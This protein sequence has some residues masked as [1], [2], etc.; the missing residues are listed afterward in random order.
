MSDQTP[1]GSIAR[2]H[3]V[4]S[5]LTGSPFGRSLAEVI[6]L[7]DF[8]KTTAHRTLQSL[9]DVNYVFQDPTNRRYFL[10]SALGRLARCG[11]Q[12]DIATLAGR[13]MTRLAERTGDTIF[14]G[15]REGAEVVCVRV[16]LGEYPI[17]TLSQTLGD[18]LPIG[19]GSTGQALFAA[20]S[21]TER[22][23][24]LRANANWVRDYNYTPDMVED[25][26]RDFDTRGYALNQGIAVP[27]MIGVGL[28]VVA[29][30]G[31]AIA[32]IGVGA[33]DTRMTPDRIEDCVVPA[34]KEEIGRLVE[35]LDVLEAEGLF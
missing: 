28:P 24:I 16:E 33:I 32:A 18:R 6:A 20:S 15:V 34:M 17:R 25:L 27:Q 1:V 14:L 12:T 2:A 9:I 7:T 35:R 10:G 31:R 3:E 23:A 13:A 19:V 5:A 11:N 8:S 21:P 26:V 30:N 4:L 22:S 29:G